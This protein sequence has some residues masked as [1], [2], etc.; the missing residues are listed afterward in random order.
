MGFLSSAPISLDQVVRRVIAPGRGGVAT[1]S[2]VVRGTERG[3]RIGSITY[4]AYRPMAEREIGRIVARARKRWNVAVAV[5]H[6][7]GR[8]PAGRPAVVVACAGV[9]RRE[10]FAACRFV[11]D[12]IKDRVPIWKARPPTGPR[13]KM[14][15][16]A[17]GRRARGG[18]TR[19][20]G[21]GRK[22]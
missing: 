16:S 4:E 15:M 10:G 21:H 7:L 19:R 9:H 5:R 2:G 22:R 6:R 1:F 12:A 17:Q 20:P 14:S 3:R 11:I 18:P 13:R 8:V